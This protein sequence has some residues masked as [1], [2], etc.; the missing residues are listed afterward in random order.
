MS[1]IAENAEGARQ[2]R[3][4]NN[5]YARLMRAL[6][7][8]APGLW[9]LRIDLLALAGLICLLSAAIAPGLV[10]GGWDKE[11]REKWEIAKAQ[12]IADEKAWEA[13]ANAPADALPPVQP[14]PAA[15]PLD[16]PYPAPVDPYDQN[17]NL[18]PPAGTPA[19]D[20][21]ALSALTP[22]IKY[23]DRNTAAYLTLQTGF[24]LF[25]LF[26]IYSIL[27]PT[28]LRK[29]TRFQNK[30]GFLVLGAALLW[31]VALP[32]FVMLCV[33]WFASTTALK[34]M[35]LQDNAGRPVKYNFVLSN[36]LELITIFASVAGILAIFV[37]SVLLSSLM[38]AI[39]A[40]FLA[41]AIAIGVVLVG[42][43]VIGLPIWIAE[44]MKANFFGAFD[45]TKPIA[46]VI[47]LFFAIVITLAAMAIISLLVFRSRGALWRTIA[48][49]V[50]TLLVSPALFYG[51][52]WV[53]NA[54]GQSVKIRASG[55]VFAYTLATLL[56]LAAIGAYLTPHLIAIGGD[57]MHGARSRLTRPVLLSCFWSAPVAIG[58]GALVLLAT[59]L[60]RPVRDKYGALTGGSEVIG[61][62]TTIFL[63]VAAAVVLSLIVIELF[64]R[65]TARIS[66]LPEP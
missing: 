24:G 3:G 27:Q 48:L 28:R 19:F 54:I 18:K 12:A 9:R 35:P 50:L 17:G 37:K 57:L 62:N 64:S 41:F 5:P 21:Y 16:Q 66:S 25:G 38:R 2:R 20:A 51:A 39:G 13:Y 65:L 34:N 1:T 46:F 60:N 8:R 6:S 10:V 32:A 23:S 15:T 44:Q 63:M 61:G 47:F 59:A 4:I 53:A 22:E 49:I 43:D 31:F 29:V 36:F 26:W 33:E 52:S 11:V 40:F 55:S 42:L 58:A 30:P 7:L 45:I 14:D 56:I